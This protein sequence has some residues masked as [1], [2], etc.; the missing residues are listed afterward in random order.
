[1]VLQE[2]VTTREGLGQRHPNMYDHQS[3]LGSFVKNMYS[4]PLPWRM[5][6]QDMGQ[7]LRAKCLNSFLGDSIQLGSED[8]SKTSVLPEGFIPRQVHYGFRETWK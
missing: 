7:V 5:D 2:K 6:K 8:L 1:M 4:Q 3:H